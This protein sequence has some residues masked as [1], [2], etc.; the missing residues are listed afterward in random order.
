MGFFKTLLRSIVWG[1]SPVGLKKW[2]CPVVGTSN[3]CKVL[4]IVKAEDVGQVSLSKFEPTK[5]LVDFFGRDLKGSN[6]GFIDNEVKVIDYGMLD[7]RKLCK[8]GMK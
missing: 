6:L 4:F 3:D 8:L 2:L 5:I 7:Y 1:N